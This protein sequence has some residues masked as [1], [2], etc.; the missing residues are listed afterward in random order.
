MLSFISL[1]EALASRFLR[2]KT[3]FFSIIRTCATQ[4]NEYNQF[5][6][7]NANFFY[8]FHVSVSV[9]E[10]IFLFPFSSPNSA[11]NNTDHIRRI[12]ENYVIK[13]GDFGLSE[14]IYCKEYFRQTLTGAGVIKLP[15]KWMALE[16]LQDGV[17]GE[18]T[19]VVSRP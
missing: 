10:F 17:F 1:F 7:R 4:A 3:F 9:S 2:F 11:I 14:D 6:I 8:H 16:S 19:D 13:V 18:K 15:I 5:L 12:D